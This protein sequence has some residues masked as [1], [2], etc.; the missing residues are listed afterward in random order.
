MWQTV[1]GF[2]L[3]NTVLSLGATA[4]H[5]LRSDHETA[6][7]R[8]AAFG[9]GRPFTTASATSDTPAVR[10]DKVSHFRWWRCSRS[11]QRLRYPAQGRRRDSVLAPRSSAISSNPEQWA[12]RPSAHQRKAKLVISRREWPYAGRWSVTDAR[13]RDTEQAVFLVGGLGSRPRR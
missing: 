6:C 5:T 4:H 8:P 13:R 9:A 7:R 11:P 3:D 12:R 1:R 2:P 10:I